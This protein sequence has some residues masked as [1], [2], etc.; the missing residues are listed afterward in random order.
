MKCISN[1]I[2]D[3]V[4]N[5]PIQVFIIGILSY[6]IAG[7]IM[8]SANEYLGFWFG[9]KGGKFLWLIIAFAISKSYHWMQQILS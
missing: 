3:F 1:V 8:R 7:I 5:S 4:M 9:R 6:I 2:L